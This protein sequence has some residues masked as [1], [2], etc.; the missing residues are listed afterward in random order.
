MN[1]IK[2]HL[3][4]QHDMLF[5]ANS[6]SST[7]DIY[8]AH[9]FTKQSQLQSV[10]LASLH[11]NSTTHVTFLKIKLPYLIA[12][13]SNG[14]FTLWNLGKIDKQQEPEE[15]LSYFPTRSTEEDDPV[16]SVSIKSPILVV[17]TASHKLYIF[18]LSLSCSGIDLMHYLESPYCW[19]PI[20]IEIQNNEDRFWKVLIC[21]GFSGEDHSIWIMEVVLS[22]DSV[23]STRQGYKIAPQHSTSVY[24]PSANNKIMMMVFSPPYL[25]TAHPNNTIKHY[26]VIDGQRN[27]DH[28]PS[29]GLSLAL[30]QTLYGH[31]F[32]VDALSMD[33]NKLLSADKTGIKV[34]DAESGACQVT[35]NNYANQSNLDELPNTQI[36]TLDFDED[37]IVAIVY[38][39]ETQKYSLRL[40]SFNI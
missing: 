38:H 16:A 31:T 6:Q 30:N 35:L 12:G 14:G 9:T 36:E 39:S 22:L 20:A 37:K 24:L 26:Q 33:S 25:I 23:I 8:E 4:F 40:W 11:P 13:Y 2:Y 18:R 5:I 29:S 1:N 15:V 10:E 27:N 34:W 21:C 3:Q 28:A 17:N 32:K 19:S 7:I